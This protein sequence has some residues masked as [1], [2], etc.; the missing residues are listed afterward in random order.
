LKS[1]ANPVPFMSGYLFSYFYFFVCFHSSSIIITGYLTFT[2][3]KMHVYLKRMRVL[4]PLHQLYTISERHDIASEYGSLSKY[5]VQRR[6]LQCIKMFCSFCI[7][8]ICRCSAVSVYLIS[9][10]VLQFL[11][12][13][14]LKMFCSFCV[15]HI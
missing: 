4:I 14:Y 15:P 6:W 10:D 12:T 3:N 5:C 7:P 13:S 2:L 9:E 1:M 8:H 11:C